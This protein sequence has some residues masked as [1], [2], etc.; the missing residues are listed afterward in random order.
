LIILAAVDI[1][2][3]LL[4][5][6]YCIEI[7]VERRSKWMRTLQAALVILSTP[8]VG[9]TSSI[10]LSSTVCWDIF[11]GSWKWCALLNRVCE[12]LSTLKKRGEGAVS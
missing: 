5:Y 7:S 1:E 3:I 2:M 8:F 12:R 4:G 11:E 9:C 6:Q 10:D